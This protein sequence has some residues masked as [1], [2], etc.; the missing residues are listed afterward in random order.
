MGV[1]SDASE[2]ISFMLQQ[3][4]ISAICHYCGE[5]TVFTVTVADGATTPLQ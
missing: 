5:N 1:C 4:N 3:R 2:D